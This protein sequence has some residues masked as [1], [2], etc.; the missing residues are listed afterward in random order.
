MP[1]GYPQP[2]KQPA[3]ED[4]LQFEHCTADGLTDT[5]LFAARKGGGLWV[6]RYPLRTASAL[7]TTEKH[8]PSFLNAW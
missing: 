5:E 1:G 8:T 7:S 6:R 3:G 2:R 4:M